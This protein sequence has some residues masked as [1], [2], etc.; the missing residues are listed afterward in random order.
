MSLPEPLSAAGAARLEATV[1][2]PSET[3]DGPSGL[4]GWLNELADRLDVDSQ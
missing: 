3:V 4:A 1:R 2:S